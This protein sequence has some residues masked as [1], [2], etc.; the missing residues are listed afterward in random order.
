MSELR[1]VVQCDKKGIPIAFVVDGKEVLSFR[2][3]KGE[4]KWA[5]VLG[6]YLKKNVNSDHLEKGP[7]YW[8]G[9]FPK[10]KVKINILDYIPTGRENAVTREYLMAITGRSDRRC[11]DYITKARNEGARIVSSSRKKGYWMA[12]S[13]EEWYIFCR[14]HG[15]RFAAIGKTLREAKKA[16]LEGQVRL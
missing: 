12:T 7:A 4:T 6:E 3:F 11:R 16:P 9:N 15:R 1:Y 5:E 14:E 2:R 8:S 10:S 13:D